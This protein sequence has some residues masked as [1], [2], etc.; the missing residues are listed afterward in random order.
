M[1]ERDL[2]RDWRIS[3]YLG[4]TLRT[5]FL[6][7]KII[8]T[9]MRIK[10]EL[11]ITREEKKIILRK[12]GLKIGLPEEIC[13]RPKKAAQYGSMFEKAIIRIAKSNG[14]KNA[15]EFLKSIY[16]QENP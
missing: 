11:K 5:P 13:L 6:D 4:V 15:V 12:L 7:E 8:R 16:E 3:T 9:A 1:Y 2:T 10:Q 14:Y